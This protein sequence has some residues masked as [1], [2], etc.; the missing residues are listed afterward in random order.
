MFHKIARA[1]KNL[2]FM[3]LSWQSNYLQKRL[4]KRL[5]YTKKA[6]LDGCSVD[7]S[8]DLKDKESKIELELRGILKQCKNNPKHVIEF[9]ETHNIPVYGV[10]NA[11]RVTKHLKE[12]LGFITERKGLSALYLNLIT[13]NGFKFK[14]EPMVILEQDKDGEI[15]IY[16]LIYALHKWYSM[17]EGLGGFDA[18]SQKLLARF[19]SK[20]E[21]KLIGRLSIPEIEGLREAIARDV[22]AIDFVSQ[23][24]RENTGSKKALEKMQQEG[25]A[26][27]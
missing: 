3:I 6:V 8:Q 1:V 4:I 2:S 26:S 16:N 17:K 21:D 24:S 19:N 12:K 18:K 20:N 11:K 7:I 14:T 13:K 22:K 10:A 23:Y 5:G 25:G 9:F 27:I 15:D